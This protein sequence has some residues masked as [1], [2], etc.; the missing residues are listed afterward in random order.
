[1]KALMLVLSIILVSQ[2]ALTAEK[3]ISKY[4]R[5]PEVCF[6]L[7]DEKY[8]VGLKSMSGISQY[9]FNKISENVQKQM[10]SEVKKILG[11]ELIIEKLWEDSTVDA[12]AT[13]DDVNNAVIVVHGGLARHPQ[14]TKDAFLLILCHEVGHHLGGAPKIP[15]GNSG[16]RSWSSAEGQA[17][18]FATTKCLP[19]FLKTDNE[20]KDLES[21]I[22]PTLF[23]TALSKCRDNNCARIALVGLQASYVFASMVAGTPEPK[24][25]LNDSTKVSK[26][27]FNH[28]SPQCRL[29]T[30][31][32]G[33]NCDSSQDVPFD[34]ADPK[35]GACMKESGERPAC[36]FSKQNF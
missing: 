17:D 27:L 6:P 14:M 21:E 11:K 7:S 3:K 13:R 20:Y 15:R 24:L 19:H 8:P 34:S 4:K 1:M 35:I 22:D 29:D 26:T 28:P 36:W 10:S 9:D 12:Y 31:L 18:Y 16:L 2:T 23:K 5:E 25:N 32:A 30:F 33:A